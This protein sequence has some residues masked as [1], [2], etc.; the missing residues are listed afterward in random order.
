MENLHETDS[1]TNDH[2]KK[3]F[4]L[5]Y[6]HGQFK[7]LENVCRDL[8][9]R[10]NVFYSPL[11]YLCRLYL[12][13]RLSQ[14]ACEL[15]PS[16]VEK[17]FKLYPSS[18]F[19]S[20]AQGKIYYE[21]GHYLDGITWLKQGIES[22][23]HEEAVYLLVLCLEKIW[24]FEG[25][26]EH[27]QR[28]LKEENLTDSVR[29]CFSLAS[30]YVSQKKYKEANNFLEKVPALPEFQV[31]RVLLAWEEGNLSDFD[32]HRQNL[33]EKNW[34]VELCQILSPGSEESKKESLLQLINS[35]PNNFDLLLSVGIE[36]YERS[37]IDEAVVIFQQVTLLVMC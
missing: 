29:F 10:F 32:L 13:K 22:K 2:H 31:L 6:K 16:F 21:T 37:H 20:F 35:F 1:A 24:D 26:E 27:C 19:G 14:E 18:S 8:T 36:F 23:L 30:S 12:E 3:Y 17:L 9:P 15:V 28:I 33:P 4:Q 5:L 7:K 11:D 25:V 34:R